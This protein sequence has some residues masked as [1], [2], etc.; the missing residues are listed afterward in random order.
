MSVVV[1]CQKQWNL[2]TLLE[3]LWM[4]LEIVRVYTKKRGETPAF[5]EPLT[6]TPQRGGSLLFFSSFTCV[7]MQEEQQLK[8]QFV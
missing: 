4:N 2:D 5:T 7:S 3:Q 8:Q 1:S 6:L